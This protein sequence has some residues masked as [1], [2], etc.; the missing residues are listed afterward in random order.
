MSS[1]LLCVDERNEHSSYISS[2]EIDNDNNEYT[3]LCTLMDKKYKTRKLRILVANDDQFQ[4]FIISSTLSK[5]NFVE[6]I[7][8]AENGQDA[9]DKVMV[10]EK[11]LLNGGE[12]MYDLIFLDLG[13]PIKNG[14]QACQSILQHYNQMHKKALM[15]SI[16]NQNGWL[17]DLQHLLRLQ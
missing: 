5:L 9:L 17:N 14:Y 7:H 15:S 10:N 1:P 16:S 3:K 2:I 6:Y 4:L 8:Q 13:M 11:G 12:K